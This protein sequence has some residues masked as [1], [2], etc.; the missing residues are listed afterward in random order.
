MR[1]LLGRLALLAAFSATSV[2]AQEGSTLELPT[3]VQAA[4]T[5]SV[6]TTGS[7]TATFYLIGPTYTSR[8]EVELGKPIQVKPEELKSAGRYIAMLQGSSMHAAGT[9]FVLAGPPS[10][11]SF[12]AHPS[13]VPVG[14]NDGILGEVFVFDNHQNLVLHPVDVNFRL[15][16]DGEN[17]QR[18]VPSHD[19]IAWVT[20]N[21]TKKAG[22]TDFVASVAGVEEK[23]VIQQVA[24]DPCNLRMKASRNDKGVVAETDPVRDCTGNLVSDGTVVT[25]TETDSAGKSTVDAPV[26][27]GIARA[28][29][30]PPSGAATVSVASGVVMGNEVRVGGSQ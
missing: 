10:Q 23:R 19:G 3:T 7:G 25:F 5:L 9:F 13:R 14:Q 11:L 8:T 28:E 30:A 29:L 2:H 22:N 12:L 1:K 6:P 20:I 21:S 18:T 27:K 16:L 4:T 24:S 26:K 15:S 17:S